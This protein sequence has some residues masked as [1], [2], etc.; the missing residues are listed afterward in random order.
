MTL[1]QDFKSAIHKQKKDI[2]DFQNEK[3]SAINFVKGV[4]KE[5]TDLEKTG[6]KHTI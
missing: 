5:A 3:W 2:V 1:S 4:G 6:A